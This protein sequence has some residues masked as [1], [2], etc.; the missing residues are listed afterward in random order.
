MVVSIL[1]YG[2]FTIFLYTRAGLEFRAVGKNKKFASYHHIPFHTY[3]YTGFAIS[4]AIGGLAGSLVVQL[5]RYMDIGLGIGSVLQ[6]LAALMLGEVILDAKTSMLRQILSPM[7]G[8][9]VYQQVSG[10]VLDLGFAP[11]DFRLLTGCMILAIF[12]IKQVCEV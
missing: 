2:L 11:T 5:N 1:V 6:A 7:L 12:Y 9:I 8:A 10:L 4:G 3:V